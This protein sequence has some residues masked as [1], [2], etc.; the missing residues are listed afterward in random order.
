MADEPNLAK[1]AAFKQLLDADSIR[2]FNAACDKPY[3]EQATFFLNAYWVEFSDQ[4]E[5]IYS[6]AWKTMQ[7]AEME[8]KG[9]MYVHQYDEGKELD[10]DS[11]LRFFEMLCNRTLKERN[12]KEYMAEWEA[13]GTYKKSLPQMQTSI[14]RK[15]ELRETVDANGN[16]KISFLEYLIYQYECDVK[17]L[18]SR[19]M[20]APVVDEDEAIRLARLALEEVQRAIKAYES[21]KQ[22][23]TD[24]S[25]DN[26]GKGIKALKAKNMLAQL[27]SSPIFEHLNTS[28][29]KAEAALRRV[30]R[31]AAARGGRVGGGEQKAGEAAP[32]RTD[33]TMWWM[34]RAI[35][36]AKEKYGRPEK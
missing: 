35:R 7:A 2:V 6:A 36:E 16:G 32:M 24:Q 28:L 31:E 27:D 8:H 26:G 33:G 12:H 23:L 14:K 29:I 10:I 3:S 21:E 5:F 4:A 13:E 20:A 30:T 18:M 22:R 1:Q 15:R 34:Q 17:D 9:I 11:S 25:N 19:V